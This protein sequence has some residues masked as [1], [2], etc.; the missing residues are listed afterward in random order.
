MERRLREFARQLRT[1]D[2]RLARLEPKDVAGAGLRAPAG[3]DS[4]ERRLTIAPGIERDPPALISVPSLKA[5]PG[6]R[7]ATLGGLTQRYSP[8]WSLADAGATA[9]SI[10]R[11]TGLPIGR[12]ELIL[13]LR[14]QIDGT[15][16][17][18]SHGPHAGDQE[19]FSR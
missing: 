12:I 19:A 15:R 5:S 4:A 18:A 13:S 16:T 1:I 11:A 10:A 8:I 6:D 7:E 3:A 17:T 14:R 9:E 2:S